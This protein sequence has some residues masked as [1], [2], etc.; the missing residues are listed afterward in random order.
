MSGR[1]ELTTDEK[2]RILADL[3]GNYLL[4][5]RLA[6]EERLGVHDDPRRVR[7]LREQLI[8]EAVAARTILS[9][10][11]E[12]EDNVSYMIAQAVRGPVL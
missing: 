6:V 11:P 4:L 7:E 10:Q 5:G 2:Y 1:H 3:Q 8:R 9:G 12:Q